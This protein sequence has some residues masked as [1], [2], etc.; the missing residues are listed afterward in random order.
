MN[1]KLFLLPISVA[2]FFAFGKINA[3]NSTKLIQDYYQKSGKL[4]QK[5]G[6]NDKVGVIILN[7]D[8][9][10]S[11]GAH[12]VDVQQTYDGLRVY[13]AL[14]KVIVKGDKIISEKNDFSRNV[15]V[16]QQN[17]AQGRLSED[18]I[19]QKLGLI[20]ILEIDYSS[21][22]Y[23]E[24]NGVF[25]LSKELFVS[26]AHSSDVWHVIA[27]ASSGEILSKDNMTLSCQFDHSSDSGEKSEE[28]QESQNIVDQPAFFKGT[29]QNTAGNLVVPSNA[30]YNIFPLPLEAP[31]FGNRAVV[32]NPWDLT[33]SPEGWHSDGTNSYTNTR[34]NNVYA[35]SDQGNT[36]LPGYSPDGGSARNF[37][38]PFADDRYADP[39]AYRDAAVTN[40]FYMNNKMHDVFYKF[41]FTESAR[42]FQ[43][44]NFTNGGIGGDAVRAE[45]FDGSGL[46]N[47]NFSSGYE[48]V[49]SGQ[50]QVLAPRMQMYLYDRTQTADDPIVRYQYNSPATIVSRPKVLTGGASFG[51]IFGPAVTGDLAVS[52]P[53]DACIAPAAGSLTNKIAIVTSTSCEYGLKVLNAQN[54]GAIGVIVYRPSSDTPVSMGAGNSGGQVT[55]PS[56]NIGKTEGEFM[57]AQLNSGTT[58]NATLNFDYSGFKHSSFD[59]GIIAHEY[60]HGISNRLT[61]Q[62]YSCLSTANT[63]EQMGEGWS[64]Y[65]A[66]MLT[67]RP[68]DTSALARGVGTYPKGQPITGVGIRPAQ[69]SPDFNVN[70]Y[71]YAQTNTAAIPHGVGF[72]WATMLWDLTWNYIEKYGYN[73]DVL[74]STTS[75]NAKALQIVI[76]GLKLQP[77]SPTFIDGRD[78]I[79]KADLLGNGGGDK[80]MIW[81][82]FAKRGLGVNASAGSKVVANDQVEDFTVPVE[83]NVS[84]ATDEV[85]ALNNKFIVFPNPTYDEFFIGNIDKSSQEVK[86]KMFDMSGKLVFSDARESG[87]KKAISTKELQKGVYMVHI[88][89]GDKTQTEKLIVR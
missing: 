45:A 22:V 62:G 84:L 89:Q 52:V 21:D 36:N 55:I 88:Q 42:N 4:L 53:A 81:K 63:T 9:S 32:N 54:A 41:G 30:S 67:T 23:F 75:G 17:K 8:K 24:K 25:V 56:I 1:R 35:Y 34:G 37:N 71:T 80:C 87:S 83:C 20:K 10:Q 18:L 51:P 64:D 2:V 39:F 50:N 12:I 11:L 60:G 16:A 72:I 27:D 13:N 78:A 85:K 15:V 44:N 68:G 46:N 31:T 66:L 38:F 40:L 74:A 43:T 79:L 7:E 5:N 28:I 61:G 77:C 57:I 3:Q 73:S 58:V 49:V 59:N 70:G 65:F 29:I 47:A 19:K 14:G 33:A 82:T 6:A 86:I 26:D 48:R 76:D 69:Y